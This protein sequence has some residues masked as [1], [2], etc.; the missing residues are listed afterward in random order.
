[1]ATEISQ[2]LINALTGHV[3]T[4]SHLSGYPTERELAWSDGSFSQTAFDPCLKVRIGF[5]WQEGT[6]RRFRLWRV[7]YA[8]YTLIDRAEARALVRFKNM[9]HDW[10]GGIS[11]LP[12]RCGH[13]V[14]VK[15]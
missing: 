6:K 15:S 1:M 14:R 11:D 12:E 10:N 8:Q 2:R 9:L 13:R 5:Q 4:S 3:G 7:D